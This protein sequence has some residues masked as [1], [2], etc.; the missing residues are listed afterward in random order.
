VLSNCI[1][2]RSTRFKILPWKAKYY[3]LITKVIAPPSHRCV[4]LGISEGFLHQGDSIQRHSMTVVNEV[5]NPKVHLMYVIHFVH[6]ASNTYECIMWWRL[7]ILPYVSST[8]LLYIFRKCTTAG[9]RFDSDSYRS[10]IT[11]LPPP[12]SSLEAEDR[13]LF[14]NM[15]V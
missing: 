12:P 11:N 9:G 7:C 4:G 13:D 15:F 6:R 8:K 5:L 14:H 3:T 10:G 2:L 1:F